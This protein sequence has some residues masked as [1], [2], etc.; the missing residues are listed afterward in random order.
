MAKQSWHYVGCQE[1]ELEVYTM[2]YI[3]VA[4]QH[5]ENMRDANECYENSVLEVVGE[6]SNGKERGGMSIHQ[7]EEQ[8][9]TIPRYFWT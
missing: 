5:S 2:Y 7:M 1:L 9:M 4:N 6:Q 8:K 3:N